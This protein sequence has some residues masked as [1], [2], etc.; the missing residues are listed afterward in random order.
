MMQGAPQ[1]QSQDWKSDSNVNNF[2]STGDDSVHTVPPVKP[3]E[4]S[5]NEDVANSVENPIAYE[6]VPTPF[7]P[8]RIDR[9]RVDNFLMLFIMALMFIFGVAALATPIV[10]Y[11]SPT[12]SI[13]VDCIYVWGVSSVGTHQRNSNHDVFCYDFTLKSDGFAALFII[14]VLFSV[15]GFIL[16]LVPLI[17]GRVICCRFLVQTL[18]LLC[19]F[20]VM[21][22]MILGAQMRNDAL[23]RSTSLKSIGFK[24]GPAFG[25]AVTL[26]VLF[27]IVIG[28]LIFWM[29]RYPAKLRY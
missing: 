17:C 1:P 6:Y 26:F 5:H 7:N 10:S 16:A 18:I 23:C 2:R 13:S 21:V 8:P 12:I 4:P 28:V 3:G 19:W 20:F 22:G 27:T 25:L 11:S 15:V 9:C 24:Y 29:I 14:S